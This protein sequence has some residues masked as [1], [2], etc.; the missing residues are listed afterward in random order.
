MSADA[1]PTP[2]TKPLPGALIV[3][4]VRDY[5]GD[6][7]QVTADLVGTAFG[8]PAGG[9]RGD[10]LARDGSDTFNPVLLTSR[11]RV[12]QRG[13]EWSI[14]SMPAPKPSASSTTAT[15]ITPNVSTRRPPPS[16]RPIRGRSVR[17]PS[18]VA[19]R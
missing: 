9:A 17:P 14:S 18:R 3:L 15:P 5:D 19:L 1:R 12:R 8:V 2:A 11:G 7:S 4:R 6:D 13:I 16:A 10:T